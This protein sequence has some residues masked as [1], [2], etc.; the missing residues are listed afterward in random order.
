[1]FMKE[2]N[3][4]V[5]WREEIKGY[6]KSCWPWLFPCR[7]AMLDGSWDLLPGFRGHHALLCACLH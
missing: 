2:K 5:V 1:M 4:N 6:T 7:P 3:G